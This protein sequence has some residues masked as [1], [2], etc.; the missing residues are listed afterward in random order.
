MLKACYENLRAVCAR[1]RMREIADILMGIPFL[2]GWVNTRSEGG[3]KT[4]V[5][6]FGARSVLVSVGNVPTVAALTILRNTLTRSDMIIKTPSN[7]PLTAAAIARTMVDMAPD[8]PVTKHLSVA[9]W[10]GGDARVE[11]ELYKPAHVEKIV[12]WCC[13]ASITHI[14]N[15]LQPGI[16]LITPDPKLRSTIIGREAFT[17]D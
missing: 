3:T 5:R 2:E 11:E 16:D 1:K 15:Y 7:D 12:A 9:Y 4:F 6:A 13:M 8:H 10:K 14:V 17:S